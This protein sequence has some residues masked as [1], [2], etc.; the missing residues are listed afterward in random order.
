MSAEKYVRISPQ[1]HPRFKAFAA[2]RGASMQELVEDSIE[3]LME[4]QSATGLGKILPE[5]SGKTLIDSL[6]T[7]QALAAIDAAI[8]ALEGARRALGATNNGSDRTLDND[9]VDAAA[10]I[11]RASAELGSSGG[12]VAEDRDGVEENRG[13]EQ[14]KGAP[15]L[16]AAHDV[17]TNKKSPR[18]EPRALVK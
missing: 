15:P 16:I 6:N 9:I 10:G 5:Y 17:S 4:G 12:G 3:K 11:A 18:R 13:G 1:L 8:A 14:L 7:I 2:T